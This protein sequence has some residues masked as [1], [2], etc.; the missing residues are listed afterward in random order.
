ME[1]RLFHFCQE[2]NV[3]NYYGVVQMATQSAIEGAISYCSKGKEVGEV[4]VRMGL[5]RGGIFVEVESEGGWPKVLE[6][7]PESLLAVGEK[8]CFAIIGS[9]SDQIEIDK[10]GRSIRMEFFV[11]GIDPAVAYGRVAVLQE[12]YSRLGQ[13]SR[14]NAGMM[15]Y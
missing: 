5:C 15:S 7:N 12:Y 13:E 2:N 8:D 11:T 3:G 10:S 6:C 14:V 4:C 9:L 1:E